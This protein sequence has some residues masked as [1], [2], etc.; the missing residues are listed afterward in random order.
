MV[1]LGYV[2]VLPPLYLFVYLPIQ[3]M[4]FGPAQRPSA[5]QAVTF[6]SSFIASDE[7]VECPSH[8]Y[9]TFILS[10]EPLIVYIENFLSAQESAHLIQIRYVNVCGENDSF[11]SVESLMLSKCFECG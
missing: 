6:N 2:A 10:Q 7:P 4:L 5:P 1:N 3:H 8:V 11:S 9:N